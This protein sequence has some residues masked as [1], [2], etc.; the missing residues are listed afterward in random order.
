MKPIPIKQHSRL[1]YTSAYVA[2]KLFRGTVTVAYGI[3]ALRH[4]KPR[5]RAII[6]HDGY[7]LLIRGSV[8]PEY[9]SLPGGGVHPKEQE[10]AALSREL[11]E[12]VRLHIP[13]NALYPLARYSRAQTG[14]KYDLSIY[15]HEILSPESHHVRLTPEILEAQ[16]YTLDAIP[17]NVS[18]STQLA[19]ADYQSRQ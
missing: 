15:Y 10:T 12:E 1:G 5:T 7:V 18:K 16:W 4:T 8:R 13:P 6:V 19:L 11:H 2:G 17:K 3:K 9:W 14:A